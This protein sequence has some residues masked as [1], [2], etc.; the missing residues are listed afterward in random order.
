MTA[1][2]LDDRAVEVHAL[3]QDR[4]LRMGFDQLLI[5]TGG[6]PVRPDLPGI[7]NP[8]VH[9]VQ[10]L[11]DAERLLAEVTSGDVRE[12]VVVGGGYIGLEMAEA[13]VRRG[14]DVTLLEESSQVMA[15]LDPDMA[16][17]VS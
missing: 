3:D 14:A 16:E 15:T 8:H 11:G 17:L 1:I 2:D 6:N 9:G 13:F 12:V 7:D 10:T 4:T 5:A